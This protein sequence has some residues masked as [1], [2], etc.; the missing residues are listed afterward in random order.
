MGG[1]LS[2]QELDRTL[3][4]EAVSLAES[5]RE[6]GK[7]VMRPAGIALDRLEEPSDVIAEDSVLWDVIKGYREGGFHKLLIQK[8]F[9]GWMGKVPP[10]AGVL[11]GEQFGHADAGLAVSLTVSGMP[12]SM[13]PFFS[14]ARIRRLARDYAHD[15]DGSLIGCWGCTEPD[16]GSDW[17]MGTTS[18]GSDPKL[19]PTLQAVRKGNEFVLNGQKSA[20]VS[21]GTIATHAMLHVGLDP[22]LGMHG[23]MLAFC[24]LD[25]PGITRGKPLDKIGQRALNQGELFFS[26]VVLPKSHML[27]HRPLPG[28]DSPLVRGSLGIVNGETSIMISGLAQAAYD[29][30][31]KYVSQKE[32]NGVPLIEDEYIR[33]KLFDMFVRTEAVRA[34]VR[35]STKYRESFLQPKISRRIPGSIFMSREIAFAAMAEWLQLFFRMYD[36]SFKIR[37]VRHY[38]E[39]YWKKERVKSRYGTGKYGVAAKV[40]ATEAAFQIASDALEI[41]GEE[42]LTDK[43]PIAKMMRDA[44]ASMIEDGC[45]ETLALAAAEDL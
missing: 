10:E 14:D 36:M 19:A 11:L 1:L 32:R 43:Y 13:A 37:A 16:H 26:D 2:F 40:L 6:F 5:A 4:K 31:V 20:W 34:F 33:L 41:V 15:K 35:R 25:L 38:F 8:A 42:G 18:Q 12:F 23:Q 28:G 17:P 39:K 24:P 27:Y 7:T 21:N 9:G 45:N 30:T 3:S 22:S 29:E 44:R